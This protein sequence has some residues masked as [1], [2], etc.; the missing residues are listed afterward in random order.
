M[1]A[2]MSGSPRVPARTKDSGVPPTPTQIGSGSLQRAGEDA[3]AG[4]RRAVLS[5]PGDLHLFAD[6]QEEVELLGEQRVVVGEVQP[7]QRK[8]LR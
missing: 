2:T 1:I 3:L 6:A 4:E 7:E 8:G 5:G